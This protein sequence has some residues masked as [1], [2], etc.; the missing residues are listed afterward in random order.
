MPWFALALGAI[1]IGL[2]ALISIFLLV[3]VDADPGAAD[4][5]LHKEEDRS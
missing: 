2:G 5:E 4:L 1:V 3:A